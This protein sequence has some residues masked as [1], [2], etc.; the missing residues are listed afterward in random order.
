MLIYT[1]LLN[2]PPAFILNVLNLT[3]PLSSARAYGDCKRWL[4]LD[5]H[6]QQSNQT[7][8]ETALSAVHASHSLNYNA[9]QHSHD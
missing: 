1:S 3:F 7:T 4:V 9:T 6:Y 2:Q 5:I 8:P